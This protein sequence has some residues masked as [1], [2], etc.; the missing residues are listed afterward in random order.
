M[1]EAEEAVLVGDSLEGDVELA[2]LPAPPKCMSAV[3]MSPIMTVDKLRASL[4]TLPPS[5]WRKGTESEEA[6]EEAGL[7]GDEGEVGEVVFD[8]VPIMPPRGEAGLEP[9]GAVE[10]GEKE[11]ADEDDDEVPPSVTTIFSESLKGR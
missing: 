8:K 5:R 2:L 9:P 11:E 3:A 6:L 4:P 1:S 7:R 10:E